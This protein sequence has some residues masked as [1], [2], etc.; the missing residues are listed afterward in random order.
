MKHLGRL[1]AGATTLAALLYYSWSTATAR[2]L[3]LEKPIAI[4]LLQPFPDLGGSPP[5]RWT[6]LAGKFRPDQPMAS[7]PDLLHHLGNGYPAQMPEHPDNVTRKM[8]LG[9]L[10]DGTLPDRYQPKTDWLFRGID[11]RAHMSQRVDGGAEGHPSQ[12]LAEFAALGVPS[13]RVVRSGASSASIAE[14]VR[15]L[16]EDFHLVGEIEWKAMALA[17]YAPTKEPWV[18]RWGRSFDFD[19]IVASLLSRSPGQGS[20]NGIHVLQALAIIRRV[21]AIRPILSG[22]SRD[23]I[24]DRLAATISTL[25]AGQRPG[26][27]WAPDWTTTHPNSD[28]YSQDLLMFTQDEMALVTGHHL[29]WI[30]LLGED[31]AHDLEFRQAA[32]D[33]CTRS[34]EDASPASIARSFCA[35][36]HCFRAAT[37]DSTVRSWYS[38]RGDP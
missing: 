21:D 6:R 38:K 9:D 26:G 22:S 8:L 15:S 37:R 13:S 20:C 4:P 2:A 34:L 29:E 3:V 30:D 12:M 31:L 7:L 10:L 24:R 19:A 35:Y 11:D 18:N 28:D 23:A 32:V 25:R 14:L 5:E 17:R 33:W 36:S 16:R 27:Y 1:F